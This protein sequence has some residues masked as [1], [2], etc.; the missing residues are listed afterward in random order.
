MKK[1][2]VV[3][4]LVLTVVAVL[5]AAGLA[6]A[7]TQTPGRGGRGPGMMGNGGYGPG[8]MG[9][10][11]GRGAGMMANGAYGPMHTYMVEALA[12]ALDLTPEAVQERITN[13][14]T[15]WQIAQSTGLN[16]DQVRDLLQQVHDTALDKA[17]AAGAITQEQAD[18]MEGHMDA[19]WENGFGPGAG[20][21]HQ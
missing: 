21:C 9:G 11:G 2:L 4:V 19:M 5:G 14:E 8:M 12:E 13:G 3:S 7:Q 20:P 18:W 16:D 17:V 6:Y 1:I 10:R 15:P